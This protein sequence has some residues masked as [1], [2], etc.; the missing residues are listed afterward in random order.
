MGADPEGADIAM[1]KASLRRQAARQHRQ[2]ER[3]GQQELA[4]EAIADAVSLELSACVLRAEV[5]VEV[6]DLAG[7]L[8]PTWVAT[9]T[10]PALLAVARAVAS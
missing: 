6:A 10:L 5:E 9:E 3:E 1:M 8:I 4:R 2:S 7:R